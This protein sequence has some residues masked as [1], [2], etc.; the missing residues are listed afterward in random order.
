MGSSLSDGEG[1]RISR[2]DMGVYSRW[3]GPL[4][5]SEAYPICMGESSSASPSESPRE[6]PL[7]SSY[8]HG[9]PSRE[10]EQVLQIG[11]SPSHFWTV[12]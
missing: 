2:G 4:G 5:P 6:A 7:F 3:P 8:M 12:E 1:I 10:R 11:C 9:W